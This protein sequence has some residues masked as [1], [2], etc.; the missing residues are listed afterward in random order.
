MDWEQFF[1]ENP[2]AQVKLDGILKASGEEAVKT[3]RTEQADVMLF[4]TSEAYPSAIRALAG[5][6]LA[7]LEEKSAL[8]ACITM[9]DS[10]VEGIKAAAARKASEEAGETPGSAISEGVS[11]DGAI[12]TAEDFEAA[13]KRLKGQV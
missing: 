3:L 11:E 1:K 13:V 5:K 9:Y 10:S 2:S 12:N 8:T 4:V 7:G 6:V